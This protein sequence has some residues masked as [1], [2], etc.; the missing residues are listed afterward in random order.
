MTLEVRR[1]SNQCNESS[2][3]LLTVNETSWALNRAVD[4]VLMFSTRERDKM[5]GLEHLSG[6][7]DG[8]I[9]HFP[10]RSKCERKKF[11]PFRQDKI[12]GSL[13][14]LRNVNNDFDTREILLI[15]AKILNE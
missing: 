9:A 7:T 11:P 4:K 8:R 14:R 2:S 6:S 12:R 10:T 13:K 15:V 1:D 5:Q 3:L